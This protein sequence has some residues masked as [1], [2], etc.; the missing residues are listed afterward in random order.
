MAR[1]NGLNMRQ[2]NYQVLCLLRFLENNRCNCGRIY[3]FINFLKFYKLRNIL[4]A[5]F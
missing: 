5:V 4:T 2:I 3:Y 1:E